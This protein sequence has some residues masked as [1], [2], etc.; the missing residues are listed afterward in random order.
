MEETTNA[1]PL[2]EASLTLDVQKVGTKETVMEDWPAGRR[3]AAR[4]GGGAGGGGRAG[5]GLPEP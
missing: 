3:V 1:T 2:V 4:D 5:C